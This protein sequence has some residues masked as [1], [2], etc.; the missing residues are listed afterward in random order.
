MTTGRGN[1]MDVGK[2]RSMD[3]EYIVEAIDIESDG[4]DW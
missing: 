2:G 1:I 4:G 3:P